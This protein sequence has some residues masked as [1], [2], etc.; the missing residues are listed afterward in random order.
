MT[1][2]RFALLF[3]FFLLLLPLGASAD[4]TPDPGSVTIVGS[5]QDELGCTGDWQPDCAITHLGFD[6]EDDVWQGTFNVPTGS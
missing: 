1:R 2:S 5:L 6:A 3:V 4:H